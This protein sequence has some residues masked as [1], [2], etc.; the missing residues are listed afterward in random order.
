M[1][2]NIQLCIAALALAACGSSQTNASQ[3]AAAPDNPTVVRQA[4]TLTTGD[5]VKVFGNYV[6]AT[7]AKAIILLFHQAGSSKGEYDS[8][9]PRLAARGYSSLAIDQRAGGS[10]FGTNQ[11]VQALGHS[12]SYDEAARGIQPV[13]RDHTEE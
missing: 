4:V 7:T 12:A 13:E 11:T 1:I 3:N 2:R 10:L 9:A 8:I 6:P 5:G